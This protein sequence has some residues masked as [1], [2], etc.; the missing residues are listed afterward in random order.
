MPNAAPDPRSPRPARR[1]PSDDPGYRALVRRRNLVAAIAAGLFA[2]IVAVAVLDEL[3]SAHEDRSF[4]VGPSPRLVVRDE[5]GGGLRGGITVEA[6]EPGRLHV[7]GKVHGTWRVRY[8]IEQRGDEVLIEVAPLPLLGWLS[9]LGPARF[10]ITAPPATALDV[11]SFS[12]PIAVRRITGGGAVRTTNG[13]IRLDG[14]GGRLAAT[15]TNGGIEAMGFGGAATLRTV[16]GGIDVDAGRGSFDLQTTNG[17][18]RLDAE[19]DAGGRHRAE[20]TNGGI[21]VRLRGEP[22]L[23]IVARTTNGGI[24]VSPRLAVA[25]RSPRA[26]T[27]TAGKGEGELDLRTTNGG[28]E[29]D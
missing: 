17:G 18:V 8:R 4:A 13:E 1:S 14:A 11:E 12:A 27:A 6:G 3:F 2:L 24:T 20:T 21:E 26:V 16:N 10:T 29:I 23:R 15:T 5:I 19:L 9:V 22:S 7:A 28:I 25:E